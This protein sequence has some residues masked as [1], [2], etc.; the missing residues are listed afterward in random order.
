MVQ[1]TTSDPQRNGDSLQDRINEILN[2]GRSNKRPVFAGVEQAQEVDELEFRLA[3]AEREMRAV[4]TR[5]EDLQR[6]L[7]QKR[8]KVRL[9]PP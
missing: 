7:S 8:R 3:Q 5:I 4:Q 6:E 2:G 9:N 1:K